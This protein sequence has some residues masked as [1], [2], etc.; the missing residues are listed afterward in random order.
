VVATPAAQG[1]KD[2]VAATITYWANH[3]GV[4]P[5]WMLRVAR[6][7]SGLSVSALNKNYYAGGGNPSGIFQFLPQTF[8]ANAARVGIADPNLWDFRQQAQVAAWMFA[9]GQ[10]KQW[11]CT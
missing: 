5:E 9:H 8:Y 1:S 4:D 2:E 10:S 6:C 11:E 7:E 3:Y